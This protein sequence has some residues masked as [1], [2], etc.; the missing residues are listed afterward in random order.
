MLFCRP[1]TRVE[2]QAVYRRGGCLQEVDS[3]DLEA[4]LEVSEGEGP[5]GV[6]PAGNG[7]GL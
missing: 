5:V 3:K 2:V 7:D 4:V 1:T 6:E